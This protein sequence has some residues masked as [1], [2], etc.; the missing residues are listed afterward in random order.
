MAHP[1]DN[2]PAEPDALED[3]SGIDDAVEDEGSSRGIGWRKGIVIVAIVAVVWTVVQSYESW[4]RTGWQIEWSDD[5]EA[6]LK[7]AEHPR[8]A[9]V[10]LVHKR[11]CELM[12]E[13]DRTVFSL[14]PVYKWAMGGIPCRLI[15]EEH[16]KVVRKYS[17]V[18]SPSLM[19]L[20]PE[21]KRVFNWSGRAITPEVRKRF[22]KYVV[23]HRDEGT[24]RKPPSATA[25]AA[26]SP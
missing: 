5:L 4:T 16:P 18:E 1:Q 6:C 22:L 26:E 7:R 2:R 17:L 3:L 24:Y 10:L 23:G 9:V 11:D 21:G 15:W 25:P 19:C 12:K 20:T 14:R 8:K 13:L